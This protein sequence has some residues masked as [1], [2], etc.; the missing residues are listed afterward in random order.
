[1]DSP[2]HPAPAVQVESDPDGVVIYRLDTPPESLPSVR[3]RDLAAAWDAARE[4]AR[5]AEWGAA[6]RF[7]FN[8]TDGTSTELALADPDAPVRLSGSPHCARRT[9]SRCVYGCW[10]WS[11]C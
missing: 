9:A 7:L 8:R 5:S 4:A 3:S 1:M 2:S 11:I 6:T 10:R